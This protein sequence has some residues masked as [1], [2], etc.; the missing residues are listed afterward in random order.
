M[1]KKF[2]AF[3]SQCTYSSTI[4]FSFI[5]P[6]V[7]EELLKIESLLDYTWHTSQTESKQKHSIYLKDIKVL[8]QMN[9][10]LYSE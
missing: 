5:G 7:A 4:N 6:R 9:N 10:C 3:F 8:L 2:S 1:V